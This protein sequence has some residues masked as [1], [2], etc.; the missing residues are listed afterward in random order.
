[1]HSYELYIKVQLVRLNS[2][3]EFVNELGKFECIFLLG[4]NC[5]HLIYPTDTKNNRD[6]G[7]LSYLGK[8]QTA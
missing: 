8:L 1:M 2:V 6:R 5:K 3:Y 7:K 4:H